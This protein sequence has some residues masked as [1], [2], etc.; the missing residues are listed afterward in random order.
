MKTCF[1]VVVKYDVGVGDYLFSELQNKLIDLV[2][3][4]R[5]DQ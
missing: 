5:H 3:T 1:R 2:N 4:D